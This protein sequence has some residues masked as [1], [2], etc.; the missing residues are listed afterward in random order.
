MTPYMIGMCINCGAQAMVKNPNGRVVG[1]LSGTTLINLKLSGPAN[2]D[3]EGRVTRVG[4][5][6]LCASCTPEMMTP[7][8]VKES[9]VKSPLDFMPEDS[10]EFKYLTDLSIEFAAKF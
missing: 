6:P 5:L 10:D 1:P 9:I 8:Q 4:T 3:F 7:L 2:S